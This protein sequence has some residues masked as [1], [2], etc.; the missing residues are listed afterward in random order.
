[1]TGLRISSAAR[2]IPPPPL[3]AV[4]AHIPVNVGLIR[5][6]WSHSQ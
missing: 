3:A 5:A 1:M 6:E 2:S 4:T